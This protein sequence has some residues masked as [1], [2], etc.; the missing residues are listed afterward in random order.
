MPI[1]TNNKK[2]ECLENKQVSS[3]IKQLGVEVDDLALQLKGNKS[4]LLD[5]KRKNILEKTITCIE[6][7]QE[8]RMFLGEGWYEGSNKKTKKQQ[9]QDPEDGD[10]EQDPKEARIK[11]ILQQELNMMG[12]RNQEIKE[13]LRKSKEESQAILRSAKEDQSKM[14]SRLKEAQMVID[15]FKIQTSLHQPKQVSGKKKKPSNPFDDSKQI[16]DDLKAALMLKHAMEANYEKNGFKVVGN[17]DGLVAAKKDRGDGMEVVGAPSRPVVQPRT[18]LSVS[19]TYIDQK[20]SIKPF[21]NRLT[22]L[23]FKSEESYL[24]GFWGLGITLIDGGKVLYSRKAQELG[25]SKKK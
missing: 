10:Q 20:G 8:I 9:N 2:K 15:Q 12:Q 16:D 17:N 13:E 14:L 19:L 23:A 7:L 18:K 1:N 24:I 22:T 4:C 21:F 3:Q 25:R 5:P 11:R 6:R